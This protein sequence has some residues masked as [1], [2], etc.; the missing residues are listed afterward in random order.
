MI[1]EVQ[2]WQKILL[3]LML[4]IMCLS[5]PGQAE[6]E[7][8]GYFEVT[9]S[10]QGADVLVDGM[11]AGETPVIVPVRS[12][13]NNGS[14]IRVLM[15]GFVIWEQKFPQNPFKGEILPI[16]AT[17]TPISPTGSLIVRSKPSG[18]LVTVN[19]GNGQM[20]P[21]TYQSLPTGTHLVSLFLMGF[22]PFIRTVE[23][24]PGQT[25]E[26]DASMSPRSGSG[27]L[28]VSS[29]PGG[30]TVYVDGVY[31]GITN[32][33]VGHIPPGL[34]EVRVTRAGY[35]DF[36]EWV[37]VPDKETVP[38]KAIFTPVTTMS[39]GFVVVTSDPPGASVYLDGTFFGAT[40]TGRPLE[41]TNVTPGQHQIYVSSK[42]YEDYEATLMVAAGSITPVSVRMNP[43]PMPQ[44]CAMLI[45]TSD[46]AGADITIDGRL[47][48][49]TPA[50]IETVC[51]GIHPYSISLTG[52]QEY[53][54][55][56]N[57]IPGQVLQIHA[58]LTPLAG[59]SETPQKE[60]PLSAP[61]LIGGLILGYAIFGRKR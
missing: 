52:Y 32:L 24:K 22:D 23:V 19:N 37:S 15:Q 28:Q 16:H 38:V 10:P 33:V 27:S 40:E 29:E 42:N 57:L 7:S 55:Q 51:S 3:P 48:G 17:L 39:G 45:L 36:V 53:R 59:S 41:I 61:V 14:T 5:A 49:K 6:Q 2:R 44:A 8:M 54:S 60:T 43:S 31:A 30:A 13:N 18:A 9:S 46:P 4:V 20:A 34:H 21:W 47:K 26:L 56:V 50:T 25:T 12:M 1:W 58:A 35:E 11:F